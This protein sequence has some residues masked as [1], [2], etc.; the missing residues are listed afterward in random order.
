MPITRAL[1]VFMLLA[2]FS[3]PK[4]AAAQ[5][6]TA[7]GLGTGVVAG[8]L[9]GGPIGAVVGGMAGAALGASAHRPRYRVY[10]PVRRNAY[11]SYYRHHRAAQR[12]LAQRYPVVSSTPKATRPSDP[13]ANPPV[14][15]EALEASR[16]DTPSSPQAEPAVAP[17]NLKRERTEPPAN[18]EANRPEG[19]RDPERGGDAA[20]PQSQPRSK[21]QCGVTL[22]KRPQ[23]MRAAKACSLATI[24]VLLVALAGSAHASCEDRPRPNVDWTNCS[25]KQLMLS[26]DDLTG[27]VLSRARLT[28]TDFARSRLSGA[29]LIG[30]EISFTRFGEADLSGADFERAVG[31]RANFSRANLERARFYAADMSRSIFVEA[32]LVGANFAKSEMNRSDF[33]GADLSGA[34][35]SK[36]ELRAPCS[37]EQ[38]WPGVRFSATPTRTR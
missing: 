11:R 29:Q 24:L 12:R 19:V 9:L 15:L 23:S 6:Q 18:L 30:A 28:A 27:A 38:S 7:V 10:R 1:V 33:S 34:D 32:K 2:A 31:W 25:E 36:A 17:A 26:N 21:I 3:A 5:S 22:S 8:A 13:K 37:Q 4:P 35:M 14:G 16:P 20:Q